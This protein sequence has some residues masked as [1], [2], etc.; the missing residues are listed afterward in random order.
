M[1]GWVRYWISDGIGHGYEKWK[2]VYIPFCYQFKDE[3]EKWDSFQCIID[4]YESWARF[5]SCRYD[6]EVDVIPPKEA[7]IKLIDQLN[8]KIEGIKATIKEQETFLDSLID[9]TYKMPKL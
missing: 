2:Y 6:L 7:V 8:H 1:T 5:S 3:S 4:E 9:E